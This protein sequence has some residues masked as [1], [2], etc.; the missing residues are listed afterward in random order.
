MN[1]TLDEFV[2]LSRKFNLVAVYREISADLETPVSVFLKVGNKPNSFLLE[3]VTGG[4]HQSRYSIV[5][6]DPFLVMKTKE[7]NVEIVTEGQCRNEVMKESEDPLTILERLLVGYSFANNLDIQS[8]RGGAVGFMGYD[9]ARFFEKIPI[10][11]QDDRNLPD[12]YFV[13]P[14]TLFIFDHVKH[15]LTIAHLTLVND[16]PEKTYKDASEA[17][18]SYLEVLRSPLENP[19]FLEEGSQSEATALQVHSEVPTEEGFKAV[20]AKAKER[21]LAGDIFQV[22][23]SRR[24]EVEVRVQPIQIYRALRSVNPSPY[25]FLLN[26]EDCQLIGAS[27]EILVTLKDNVVTTRPIAG[28]IRRGKN[29]E[30]DRKLETELRQDPKENAE[31]V[32][33][34]DL[35]RNDIGRVCQFGTVKVEQFMT[36]EKYSHVMH[37]VSHITGKLSGNKNR[38]DLIRATFPAGTLSGAPKVEAMKIIERLELV[39]RGPYGG[40]VGYFG[41]GQELTTAIVLRTIVLVG[42]RAFVQ[43]GAG[44]VADSDPTRE[45]QEIVIKSAAMLKAITIAENVTV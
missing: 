33:L 44:I 1:P 38:F 5:G 23:L 24:T 39:H 12:C 3:S 25:M 34:V 18:S 14:R 21:I 40:C 19:T 11:K 41:F 45:F 4:E 22:V 29:T 17:I 36:V 27:P 32:M 42:N 2:A 7:R 30:E 16:D 43:A 15:V 13:F 37:L 31:H 8:F 6:V 28:T 10:I 9:V 26:F 20:V 35:H